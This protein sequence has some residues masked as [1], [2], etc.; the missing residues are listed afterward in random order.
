MN[1]V[2]ERLRGLPGVVWAV[3]YPWSAGFPYTRGAH[4]VFRDASGK[5]VTVLAP[6]APVGPRLTAQ[7]AS[8]GVAL[9]SY[10]PG[11]REPGGTVQA[12]LVHGEVG[13][14]H[15]R[16]PLDA[17]QAANGRPAITAT[18]YDAAGHVLGQVQLGQMP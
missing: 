3:G 7:P 12:Y 4:L 2:E 1:S 16:L 10:P 15:V 5:Q 6:H 14:W 17:Q 13:F 18:A 8:G 11:H 9:F